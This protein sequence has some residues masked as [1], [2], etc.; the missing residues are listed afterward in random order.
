ME[1]FIQNK[2]NVQSWKSTPVIST[3][4]EMRYYSVLFCWVFYVTMCFTYVIVHYKHKTQL[5][6][7]SIF[8]FKKILSE[9]KQAT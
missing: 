8:I 2:G 6:N 5:F 4:K 3:V 9:E 7:F 1:E